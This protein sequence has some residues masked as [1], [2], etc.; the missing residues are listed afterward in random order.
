MLPT[1]RDAVSPLFV[2]AVAYWPVLGALSVNATVCESMEVVAAL[3]SGLLRKC[4]ENVAYLA[5]G[6][7][8][9]YVTSHIGVA[10]VRHWFGEVEEFSQI[11]HLLQ[12][13]FPHAPV[14]VEPGG[15]LQAEIAYDNH[16]SSKSHTGAIH[17]N[18]F[19][20]VMT[21]RAL[22]FELSS[23]SDIRGL[24]ASPLGTREGRELRIIHDLH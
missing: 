11:S 13:L 20:S 7:G 9:F 18:V 19:Q 5:S 23:V 6:V 22:A 24:R 17:A 1:W 3:G 14:G 15:D 8:T 2:D 10:R 16:P 21:G 4:R 12:V